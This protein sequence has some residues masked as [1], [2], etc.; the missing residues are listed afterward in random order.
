MDR[1][2]GNEMDALINKTDDAFG[3]MM[4]REGLHSGF[5]AMQLLRDFY[6]WVWDASCRF[7]TRRTA[8]CG[9]GVSF[10]VWDRTSVVHGVR[11]FHLSTCPVG[12]LEVLFPFLSVRAH[13][14]RTSGS[15]AKKR[16]P[17]ETIA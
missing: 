3:R 11:N 5:Y 12:F 17:S 16:L 7:S 13:V 6:R 2:F 10:C 8:A 15:C 9:V 1:A 14:S 4:W